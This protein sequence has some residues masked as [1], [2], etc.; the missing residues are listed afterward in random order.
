MNGNRK[1]DFRSRR[2]NVFVEMSQETVFISRSSRIQFEGSDATKILIYYN[3]LP[4]NLALS[5]CVRALYDT[6]CMVLENPLGVKLMRLNSEDTRNN[7]LEEESSLQ[8][9]KK[10]F[11]TEF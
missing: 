10:C 1:A 2:C 6:H 11:F 7:S 9:H 3:A 8:Y 4:L 5:R